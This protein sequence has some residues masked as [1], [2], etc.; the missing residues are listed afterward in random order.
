MY[1]SIALTSEMLTSNL[2]NT[3]RFMET[4]LLLKKEK[5][6]IVSNEFSANL[7]N[8]IDK[9][10]D[11]QLSALY[12]KLIEYLKRKPAK[13]NSNKF[14]GIKDNYIKEKLALT[15]ESEDK[16]LISDTMANIF[17]NNDSLKLSLKF[18]HP[19]FNPN[20][21]STNGYLRPQKNEKVTNPRNIYNIALEEEINPE[22]VLFPYLKISKKIIIRDPY[23][24]IFKKKS[25]GSMGCY[26]IW[27]DFLKSC[28]AN[29]LIN[30]ITIS[31]NGRTSANGLRNYDYSE[32]EVSHGLLTEISKNI[33]IKIT[34]LD[35]YRHDRTIETDHFHISLGKGLAMFKKQSGKYIN[36]AGDG[37]CIIITH[38]D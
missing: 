23:P 3:D 13:L 22:I 20:I 35:D 2:E 10:S 5:E 34:F 7:A 33:K 19:N 14:S 25:N 27:T 17:I 11:K 29:T 16:I 28:E 24:P 36:S 12:V 26:P 30:F 37:A 38:I 9:L 15:D 18:S 1:Q 4:I 31:D 32:E 6:L 8:S 21:Y